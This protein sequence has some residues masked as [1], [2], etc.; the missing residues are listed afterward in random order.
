MATG[1]APSVFGELPLSELT[2]IVITGDDPILLENLSAGDIFEL[3]QPYQ[4]ITSDDYIDNFDPGT[5]SFLLRGPASEN[6]DTITAFAVEDE[7]FN[8]QTI[9]IMFPFTGLPDEIEPILMENI[10]NWFGS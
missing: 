5:I 4:T 6:A 8:Q 2:D 1:S 7:G 3:D 10:I 9:F